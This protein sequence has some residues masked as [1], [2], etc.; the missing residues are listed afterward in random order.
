MNCY[1]VSNTET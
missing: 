1:K